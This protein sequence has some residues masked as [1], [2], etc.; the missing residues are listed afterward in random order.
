MADTTDT[1]AGAGMAET[2]L[3]FGGFAAVPPPEVFSEAQRKN[4]LRHRVLEE[5]YR[6]FAQAPEN[7]GVYADPE[8]K[9]ATVEQ[10]WLFFAVLGVEATLLLARPMPADQI[11][12]VKTVVRC[13][14]AELIQRLK[15]ESAAERPFAVTTLHH[16]GVTG[17]CITLFGYDP[18]RDRF[19]YHD[20]WP[21]RSLL[22]R[23]N[24][25]AGVDAQPEGSR[26]SV[27]SEELARVIYA[28]FLLPEAA[29]GAPVTRSGLRFDSWKDG[30]LFKFFHLKLLHERAENG[31]HR[32]LY[33]AGPFK[34]AV[35][36]LVDFTDAGIIVVGRLILE[37]AWMQ[38][39]LPLALDIAKSF[40]RAFAPASEAPAYEEL[41]QALGNLR[42]ARF[43]AAL[44]SGA[45]AG[46]PLGL[47][48]DTLL[49]LSVF[50]G[51]APE[52]LVETLDAKLAFRDVVHGDQ[53]L[54]EMVF[55]LSG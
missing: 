29:A 3:L 28:S 49:C 34:D 19:T 10:V 20:P 52:A 47:S 21:A 27:T 37:R 2:R 6:R 25:V 33:T 13:S 30:E 16:D 40:V 24:N 14:P 55:T 7:A 36:L 39:Q 50:A 12:R 51:G 46:P 32:H 9:G 43:A 41:A 35:S 53:K 54:L 31:M 11:T 4:P 23:E 42:D 44:L 48:R 1:T 17:H 15:D 38:K 26:W 45:A 8:G 18:A 5:A 22:C